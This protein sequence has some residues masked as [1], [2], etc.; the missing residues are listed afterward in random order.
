MR[1]TFIPNMNTCA[2][3]LPASSPSLPCSIFRQSINWKKSGCKQSW[4]RNR[5]LKYERQHRFHPYI[6]FFFL[7]ATLYSS[8]FPSPLDL[9]L[10][11][12]ESRFKKSLK[13]NPLWKT[14]IETIKLWYLRII[15]CSSQGVCMRTGVEDVST[16]L[17]TCL[18]H[19][20]AIF[21]LFNIVLSLFSSYQ[22]C[23]C[24]RRWDIYCMTT[25]MWMKKNS[26]P[27]TLNKSRRSASPASVWAYRLL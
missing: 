8:F 27:Q 12:H 10:T 26:D 19:V 14:I 2:E 25:R 11:Y 16:F 9:I 18:W 3:P 17:S 4:R 1:E 21:L 23:L 13:K 20:V 5:R 6:S 7:K 15:S 24:R 22:L